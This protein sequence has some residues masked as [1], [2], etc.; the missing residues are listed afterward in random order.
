MATMDRNRY[1]NSLLGLDDYTTADILNQPL[2]RG[3]ILPVTE[4]ADRT[5]WDMSSGIPGSMGRAVTA[6][7]RAYRGEPSAIDTLPDFDYGNG[8]PQIGS[9]S[10]YGRVPESGANAMTD[11]MYSK[12]GNDI[13]LVDAQLRRKYR[14]E[15]DGLYA[16]GRNAMFPGMMMQDTTRR[17]ILG[18]Y[19]EG[20]I[21]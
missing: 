8:F 12:S 17:G 10:S 1:T 15:P 19:D 11:F 20:P 4:Y 9:G 3:S 6:P 14:P 2:R 13:D 5:E 7:A 21:Y 16:N 18:E